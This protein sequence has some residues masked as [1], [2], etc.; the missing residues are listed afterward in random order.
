MTKKP[1]DPIQ[2]RIEKLRSLPEELRK[3]KCLQITRLTVVKGLCKDPVVAARFGVYLTDRAKGKARKRY[4]PLIDNA[5]AQLRSHLKRPEGR[6]SMALRDA[7]ADLESSQDEYQR[8]RWGPVRIIRS[9]EA[10]LAEYT[11]RCII[12]PEMSDRW[13]Y[14]LARVYAERYDSRYGTGLIPQST[15]ALKD[16]VD[17]WSKHYQG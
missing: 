5:L 3:E 6:P 17:Y 16:I 7:L 14:D 15:P 8:Q 13:G 12:H 9:K 4:R 11:L 10:L 1:R 2:G